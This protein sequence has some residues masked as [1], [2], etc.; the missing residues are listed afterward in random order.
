MKLSKSSKKYIQFITNHYT[1]IEHLDEETDKQL[2]KIY[3]EIHSSKL[4]LK[5][6]KK[7]EK[8][9]AYRKQYIKITNVEQI[10][11]PTTFNSGAFPSKIRIH[12]DE[13]IENMI[14]YSIS[15]FESNIKVHFM[16]ENINNEIEMIKYDRYFDM[17]IQWFYIINTYSINKCV[18]DLTV[19]IYMTS[20]N[21]RIPTN[22][23]EVL[24]EDHIN[25]AFTYACPINKHAE[26]VIYRAEEWFKVFIHETFHTFGL[27]F[28][29]MSSSLTKCNNEI[30]SMFK[31]KSDVNLYEAYSEFWAKIFNAAFCTY[32]LSDKLDAYDFATKL[33][34]LIYWEKYYTTFQMVKILKFLGLTYNNL[35][36][37]SKSSEMLRNN[38]YKENTSILAYYVINTVLMINYGSFLNWCDKN[39]LN[40]F[41]FKH[42]I[43]N[44]MNFCEFI[45]K[46]YKSNKTIT[47]IQ[48]TQN[49]VS[50]LKN[51]IQNNDIL[52][53]TRMSVCELV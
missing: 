17:I 8:S 36:S 45:K 46:K 16:F 31:V 11:K 52:M 9:I 23:I 6:I 47:E 1:E 7:K 32:N 14:T 24:G 33:H 53:N 43:G 37:N 21:K 40:F 28:S 4:F 18:K 3:D 27:D 42:T 48:K 25:T 2:R 15:L 35:Y 50:S 20:L 39:N 29:M 34:I 5:S 30:L 12:I 13:S 41:Q 44:I 26:I 49:I 51:N 22:S 38:L 19:Y 10:S